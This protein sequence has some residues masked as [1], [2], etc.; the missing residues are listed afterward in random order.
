MRGRSVGGVLGTVA[1]PIIV[2]VLLIS[3]YVWVQGRELDSIEARTLTQEL[4]LRRLREHVLLVLV[5]TVIVVVVGIPLGIVLA[6]S[7]SRIA[8][9]FILAVG[10][11]GQ[12][13]PAI[14]VLVILTLAFGPGFGIA[15]TSLVLYALLPIM[16]NTYVGIQQVDPALVEAARGIGMRPTEVLRRVQL[17]LAVPVILAGVRTSLTFAVGVATLAIFVN[18]GG[19]GD[20]IV[21]GIKLQRDTVLVTGAVLTASLA[22]LVDWLG[23]RIESALTP[24]GLRDPGPRT[25]RRSVTTAGPPPAPFDPAVT[26]DVPVTR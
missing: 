7:K 16:Q 15:L 23:G 17:P 21:V 8:S 13:T 10:N 6:Q 11:L 9:G 25:L 24:S 19:L 22:L 5:A 18:A 3:V 12:A 1:T 14:G 26:T 20:I 2:A 4:L